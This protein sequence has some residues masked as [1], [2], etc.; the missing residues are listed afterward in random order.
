MAMR[1][2]LSLFLSFIFSLFFSFCLTFILFSQQTTDGVPVCCHQECSVGAEGQR[3]K[4]VTSPFKQTPSNYSLW[5][6]ART[7]CW[8]ETLKAI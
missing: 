3:P 1:Q 7:V 4:C 8:W 5:T 6:L 2:S